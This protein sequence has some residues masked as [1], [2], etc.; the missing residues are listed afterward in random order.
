[1]G[2]RCLTALFAIIISIFQS[3]ARADYH[4][5][6]HEG[7]NEYPYTS[8]ETATDSIKY[9]I[10]AA[11]PGDTVF[12]GAGEY[13]E[14]VVS[15]W[16]DSN[17]AVLG[18]G[19]DSTYWWWDQ[20]GEATFRPVG[21]TL[22]ENIH[23][24]HTISTSVG[25]RLY[26]SLIVRDCLFT[27][28]GGIYKSSGGGTALVENCVFRLDPA[29]GDAVV[30]N[31]AP[32]ADIRNCLVDGCATGFFDIKAD[33]AII[34]NNI[35][36]DCTSLAIKPWSTNDSTLVANNLIYHRVPES[37]VCWNCPIVVNTTFDTLS[38]GWGAIHVWHPESTT[39]VNNSV[40][41]ATAAFYLHDDNPWDMQASYYNLWDVDYL[42]LADYPVTWDT[43]GIQ[44]ADPMFVGDEDFHVQAYSPLID[45]GDPGILDVDGSR[46]DIGV[47]GGPGGQSYDYPDLPPAIPDSISGMVIGDSIIII[48][49]FNTEAD[50]SRYQ[51]HRDTVSG[52]EP[53]I[54]NM[55]AEPDTSYYAD[56][57][58]TPGYDYYYKIAAVDNQ[59]NMSDY[60][61]EL[62]VI[63]TDI[64]G[65]FGAEMPTITAIKGNYPNPFN[66]QTTIIYTVA[67]LGPIPAQIDIDI[68]DI[69]GRKVRLLVDD[70]KEVGTHRITWDGKDDSGIDLPSGV[71]FAR[72]IQWDV[73]YMKR[74]QKLVLLR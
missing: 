42:A 54:F 44:W 2:I 56:T 35:I 22:I 52:F 38:P 3:P 16:E 26:S 48:W 64:E 31:D 32:R 41:R 57:G 5:A 10:A 18:A 20:W 24:S 25:S 1:M 43:I 11:D 71:Y 4:Y 51:L 59:D 8:W 37:G 39:Y 66:S 9:A 17:I 63:L 74:H 45:T 28:A 15:A 62:A 19:V 6:S 73:D 69:L 23:F 72:I 53:D 55:I 70:R 49:R 61:E 58:W 29:H 65:G 50:F 30:V 14:R 33:T 40:S 60:S 36:I 46:S 13:F 34:Q 68:Y 21:K 67:N 12:I 47:Y 7:S 27:E